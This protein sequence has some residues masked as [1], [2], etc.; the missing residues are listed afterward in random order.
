[1]IMLAQR[2]R[3]CWRI[4]VC[5]AVI[6]SIVVSHKPAMAQNRMIGTVAPNFA[7]FDTNAS[8][9]DLSK[10]KGEYI[11]LNFWAFW[12]DTWKA[13]MPSLTQLSTDQDTDH[14]K[15]VAISVDGTRL[16]AFER[17]TAG[18]TVPFPVLLDSTGEVSK[19]YNVTHVPTVVIIDKAGRIRYSAYGY[20]GNHVLL[21]ALRRIENR[22]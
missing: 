11:V 8:Y 21:S 10:Q 18:T 17:D 22:G 9:F 5:L 7:L 19:Q 13:E 14:F 16:P 6:M 3:F 2:A 1:M 15:L 4:A 20:P 12:C